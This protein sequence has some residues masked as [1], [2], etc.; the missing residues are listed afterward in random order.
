MNIILD[1]FSNVAMELFCP[2]FTYFALKI[3]INVHTELKEKKENQVFLR[4]FLN[5]KDL[6]LELI[7]LSF[8]KKFLFIKTSINI[9]EDIFNTN[10]FF[11]LQFL[12]YINTNEM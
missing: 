5:K 12:I 6:R 9:G 8:I 11:K 1:F 4:P 10:V 3:V 2:R 7:S